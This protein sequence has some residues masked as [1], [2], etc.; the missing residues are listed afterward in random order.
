[1]HAWQLSLKI[2][3]FNSLSLIYKKLFTPKLALQLSALK[4][5]LPTIEKFKLCK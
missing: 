2:L 5:L 4:Q 1:M 3:L